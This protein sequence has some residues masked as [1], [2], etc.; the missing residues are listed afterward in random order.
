MVLGRMGLSGAS[1]GGSKS[2]SSC[3]LHT[4]MAVSGWGVSKRDVVI[5]NGVCVRS[6]WS[7]VWPPMM[8]GS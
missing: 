7:S 1:G 4:T 5:S 6:N 8:V 2:D 3:T